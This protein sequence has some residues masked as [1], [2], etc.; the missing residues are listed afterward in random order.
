MRNSD[1]NEEVDYYKKIFMSRCKKKLELIIKYINKDFQN[2]QNNTIKI[3]KK[4]CK[5]GSDYTPLL[6]Y[7]S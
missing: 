4:D 2:K 7:L 1:L 3:T 6:V 5:G